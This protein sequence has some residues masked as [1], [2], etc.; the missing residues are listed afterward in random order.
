MGT[1]QNRG[2]DPTRR[3]KPPMSVLHGRMLAEGA[4]GSG[5]GGDAY[6]VSRLAPNAVTRVRD[7]QQFIKTDQGWGKTGKGTGKTTP[8]GPIERRRAERA[9]GGK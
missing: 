2:A 5:G 1:P 3:I 4:L 9:F 6:R 7:Q 8:A